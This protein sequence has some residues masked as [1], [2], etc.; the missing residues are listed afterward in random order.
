MRCC[1]CCYT[2]WRWFVL[3]YLRLL[4]LMTIHSFGSPKVG[5]IQF[6]QS[7]RRRQFGGINRKIVAKKQR[8]R[9]SE[10]ENKNK[11]VV[12]QFAQHSHNSTLRSMNSRTRRTT[13]TTRGRLMKKWHRWV[14][15]RRYKFVEGAIKCLL[16]TSVP[17]FVVVVS[18]SV[19]VPVSVS[20]SL[21]G[22]LFIKKRQLEN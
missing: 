22:C 20:V 15:G 12:A 17:L 14:I 8:I 19:S 10:K 16:A 2:N 5:L 13:T 18:D 21:S 7:I 4:C 3:S 1:C 9:A 11:T 6:G